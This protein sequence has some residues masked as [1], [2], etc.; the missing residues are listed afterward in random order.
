LSIAAH[1]P[2]HVQLV[3]GKDHTNVGSFAKSKLEP[4]VLQALKNACPH[5]E[6]QGCGPDMRNEFVAKARKEKVTVK[7]ES[8][9]WHGKTEI[10]NLLINAVA[11]VYERGIWLQDNC[12]STGENKYMFCSTT[13]RVAISFPGGNYMNVSLD[14]PFKD[15]SFSC[16]GVKD[17]MGHFLYDLEPQINKAVRLE[18]WA[19]YKD[20]GV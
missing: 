18:I 10:Y 8:A 9:Q 14:S 20:C 15:G 17:T 19:V 12:Y 6:D 2:P 3:I 13:N 7:V 4:E 11:G 1:E 5:P 16:D